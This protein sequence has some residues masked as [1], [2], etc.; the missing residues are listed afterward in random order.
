MSVLTLKADIN[1]IGEIS[2]RH[3]RASLL[4]LSPPFR[5]A[6]ASLRCLGRQVPATAKRMRLGPIQGSWLRTIELV[7]G[8]A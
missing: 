4:S 1:R 8:K 5:Y 2:Y 7:L 6:S 3:R